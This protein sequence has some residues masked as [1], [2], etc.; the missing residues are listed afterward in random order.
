[1]SI[2][3]YIRRIYACFVCM[4]VSRKTKQAKQEQK[5][6]SFYFIRDSFLKCMHA[7]VLFVVLPPT[8]SIR[9][10]ALIHTSLTNERMEEQTTNSIKCYYFNEQ[11]EVKERPNVK[12]YISFSLFPPLCS[13]T[14]VY[15][16]KILKKNVAINYQDVVYC[17][18]QRTNEQIIIKEMN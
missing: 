2:S 18:L 15:I 5:P 6:V 10:Q 12:T 11:L 8:H 17:K 1:M 4:F 3:V 14:T 16:E 7:S 13:I 9:E